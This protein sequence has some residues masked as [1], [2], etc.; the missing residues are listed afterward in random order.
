MR[1][2]GALVVNGEESESVLDRVEVKELAARVRGGRVRRVADLAAWQA[3]AFASEGAR[4]LVSP[5]LV[6]VLL[7]LAAEAFAAA[8]GGRVGTA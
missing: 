3:A 5:V 4:S 1:R 2:V 6:A 8:A 7:L